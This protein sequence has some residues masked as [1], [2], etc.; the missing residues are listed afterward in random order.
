MLVGRKKKKKKKTSNNRQCKVVKDG[1]CFTS[2][3]YFNRAKI[4]EKLRLELG[5]EF[6]WF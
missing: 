5:L 1:A 3:V 2:S 4:C 6:S